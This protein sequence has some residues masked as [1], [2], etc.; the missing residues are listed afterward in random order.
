MRRSLYLAAIVLLATGQA[1]AVSV[2]ELS[3]SCGDDAEAWC[4]GIAYGEPMQ[5]CIDD[6]YE[7]LT[8]ACKAIAD[9]LRAGEKVSLF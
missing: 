5:A 8:P 2:W 4:K 6:N 3:R 9:R 7:K 1:M